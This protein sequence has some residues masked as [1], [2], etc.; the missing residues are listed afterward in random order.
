M[1]QL[2]LSMVASLCLL[3]CQ[4]AYIIIRDRPR[5]RRLEEFMIDAKI[6][7]MICRRVTVF[8]TAAARQF[9]D[10]NCD[11]ADLKNYPGWY[12][13]ISDPVGCSE[14]EQKAAPLSTKSCIGLRHC[15]DCL[16]AVFEVI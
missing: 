1:L 5:R 12:P 9:F 10:N 14:R 13:R 16:F 6:I 11:A 15:T 2:L 7:R 8:P 3:V 4:S